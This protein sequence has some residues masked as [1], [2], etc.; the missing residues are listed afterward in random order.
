[1]QEIR[2]TGKYLN[3]LWYVGAKHALYR[4]DGMWYH[5][6]EEFPGALFDKNGYVVFQNRDDY[7][8]SPYLQHAQDLHVP[9]G[10]A[11]IPD[12]VKV[13]SDIEDNE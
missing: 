2:I 6:L 13:I 7:I 11:S 12:Y 1:M 4:K 9:S 8:S 5:H 3:K 10:I